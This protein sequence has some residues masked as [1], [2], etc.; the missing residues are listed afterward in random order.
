VCVS[1][2]VESCDMGI[3]EAAGASIIIL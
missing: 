3:S 2:R 1:V